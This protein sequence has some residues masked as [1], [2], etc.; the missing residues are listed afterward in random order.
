MLTQT[1]QVFNLRGIDQRWVTEPFNALF[2][3]DMTWN[4]SDSWSTS[5]GWYPLFFQSPYYRGSYASGGGGQDA[6]DPTDTGAHFQIEKYV[7]PHVR[8][9]HWFSQHNGARQFLVYEQQTW[10]NAKGDV[11]KDLMDQGLFGAQAIQEKTSHQG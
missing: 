7:F 9:M 11:S 8:S 5:G 2:I 4:T 10:D 6:S 3:Q 1:F